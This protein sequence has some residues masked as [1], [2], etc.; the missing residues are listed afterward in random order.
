MCKGT[1]KNGGKES[2]SQDVLHQRRIIK[3]KLESDCTNYI[4]T[5]TFTIKHT[6][7]H[8]SFYFLV[9]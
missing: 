3:K 4:I 6:S 9:I 1:G 5:F 8:F 7:A 2:R